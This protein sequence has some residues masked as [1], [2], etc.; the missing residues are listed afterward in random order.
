MEDMFLGGL[1][2]YKFN[3]NFFFEINYLSYKLED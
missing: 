1:I 3:D 2:G